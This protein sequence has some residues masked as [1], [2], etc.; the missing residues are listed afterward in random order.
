M[1]ADGF[2]PPVVATYGASD[3]AAPLVVLL[4]GRGSNEREILSLAQH[5][6]D[7][8]EYAA[9]RAPIAEGGGYAWFANRGIGRPVATSLRSTMD[10]FRA[11]LDDAAP[12]GRPVLLVGFSGGAAFAGGL[13]LDDPSRYAGAAILYGTLPFDA[14]VPVEPGRLAGVSILVAQGDADHV[15]PRELLDRTWTYLTDEAG[16][17]TSARRGPGG[18]GI[19]PAALHEL[20]SWIAHLTGSPRSPR[21]RAAGLGD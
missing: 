16:A 12:A 17:E 3:P 11:W 1:T 2:A 10:R 5:L 4:H 19:T 20:V 15:I 14:G 9:V 21:A 6:P 13:V 18:H 8:P 7:G